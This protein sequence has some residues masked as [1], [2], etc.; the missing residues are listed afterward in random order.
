MFCHIVFVKTIFLWNSIPQFVL[1]LSYLCI[2]SHL[3]N[4]R[5][6]FFCNLGST[7]VQALSLLVKPCPLTNKK[8]IRTIKHAADNHK[9]MLWQPQ[10]HPPVLYIQGMCVYYNNKGHP[11]FKMAYNVLQRSLPHVI[12][13]TDTN[14]SYV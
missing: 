13:N 11:N 3:F 12:L 6:F 10:A 2:S 14:L 9:H 1:S 8:I 4:L 5:M 7:L